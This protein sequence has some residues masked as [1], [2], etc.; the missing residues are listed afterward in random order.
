[1]SPV[2]MDAILR[3]PLTNEVPIGFTT[4]RGITVVVYFKLNLLRR[5][6]A[7]L[8]GAFFQ[9]RLYK[10]PRHR[11]LMRTKET[12]VTS[13]RNHIRSLSPCKRDMGVAKESAYV[14]TTPPPP[15]PHS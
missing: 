13:L 2:S 8:M 6:K 12:Y 4:T 14:D 3:R 7:M 5:E 9:E 10:N 11:A 15:P 1:M